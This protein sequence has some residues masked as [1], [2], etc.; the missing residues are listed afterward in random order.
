MTTTA[1][2][3]K[4][5]PEQRK[6][7]WRAC[8]HESGHV[9]VALALGYWPV[10]VAVFASG[11]G[12]TGVSL[13]RNEHQD[14][15]Q[16]IA[17]EAAELLCRDVAAPDLEPTA[18]AVQVPNPR[19]LMAAMQDRHA[20][21]TTDAVS[22]GRHVPSGDLQQ[23]LEVILPACLDA[24]R[25]INAHRKSVLKIARMLF[26]FGVLPSEAIALTV[27]HLVQQAKHLLD[28]PAGNCVCKRK[29]M[30]HDHDRHPVRIK[31]RPRKHRR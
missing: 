26:M 21:A 15:V 11:G 20:M 9:V 17:G 23:Q 16:A 22:L 24:T 7:R 6:T 29:E 19:S 28:V 3:P 27:P 25:I 5:T 14:M 10:N 13:A 12:A 4:L 18:T 30:F 1:D 8:V 2:T 31:R